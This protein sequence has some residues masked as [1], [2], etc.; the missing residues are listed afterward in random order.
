MNGALRSPTTDT[1]NAGANPCA[2]RCDHADVLGADLA[3]DVHE[4][5][6]ARVERLGQLHAASP[7]R[8][9]ARRSAGRGR[10]PAVR[11]S[12]AR[13]RRRRTA[14]RVGKPSFS[15][16]C[17]TVAA[18]STTSSKS[19]APT[20]RRRLSTITTISGR[21]VSTSCL[22]I[23][24]PG[25]GGGAPVDVAHVVAGDVLAEL[26]ERRGALGDLAG[27]A[28]EVAEPAGREHVQRVAAWGG[29]RRSRCRSPGARR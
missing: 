9:A 12:P 23:M 17:R 4:A 19:S 6:A 25:A 8:S 27:R 10:G 24:R 5:P 15:A 11:R 26:M 20:A 22:T 14:R 7:R 18:M 29:R 3:G 16:A 2:M 28:L 1:R 21:V 13:W